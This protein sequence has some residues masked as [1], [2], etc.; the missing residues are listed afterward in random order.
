MSYYSINYKVIQNLR[1]IEFVT[2]KFKDKTDSLIK[3]L[4]N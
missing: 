1:I 3:L 4:Y 2:N